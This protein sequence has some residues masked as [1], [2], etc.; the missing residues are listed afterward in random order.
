MAAIIDNF[1][2]NIT[3]EKRKFLVSFQRVNFLKK[4]VFAWRKN[5]E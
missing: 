2:E 5:L 4:V 1:L 3:G